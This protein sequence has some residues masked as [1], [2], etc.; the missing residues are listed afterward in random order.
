MLLQLLYY[1]DADL[2]LDHIW[3]SLQY[4][5][6]Q[7]KVMKYITNLL[8]KIHIRLYG[9]KKYYDLT[10]EN[11]IDLSLLNN[12]EEPIDNHSFAYKFSPELWP[13]NH[14][15]DVKLSDHVYRI[16]NKKFERNGPELSI[17]TEINEE[18]V[19]LY[20]SKSYDTL[21][22][23]NESVK[24]LSKHQQHHNTSSISNLNEPEMEKKKKKKKWENVKKKKY[25]ITKSN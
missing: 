4:Y 5:T 15:D 17:K 1:S 6:D 24:H 13:N 16:N 23:M 21:L 20:Q 25:I 9:N 10:Q 7:D 2:Q 11:T 18:L 3:S 14:V 8:F 22:L 12:H 19:P